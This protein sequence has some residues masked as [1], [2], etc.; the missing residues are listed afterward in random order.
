MEANEI[1]KEL[2]ARKDRSAWNKGVTLYAIELAESIDDFGKQSES[3]S[4]L[5]EML[6]N[7][8]D[9]WSCYSWG[10]CSLTYNEDIAER[11]CSQSEIKRCTNSHGL[12]DYANAHEHWLDV[13]ACA[14]HQASICVVNVARRMYRLK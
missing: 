13:Q 5:K 12:R 3:V 4:E 7:G 11:L 8:A 14:L 1:V 9:D 10:G 2:E 6:L